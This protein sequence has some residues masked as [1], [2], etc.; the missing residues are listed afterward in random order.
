MCL[1]LALEP[2]PF[3]AL[4]DALFDGYQRLMPRN[5]ATAPAVIVA[6][7]ERALDAR[8]Q[9]PW[10][11]TL[12]AE[13]ISAIGAARPAAVGVDLLFVEPDRSS[14]GADAV[15]AQALQGQRVVMGIAGLTAGSLHPTALI[16]PLT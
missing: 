5:R 2:P 16:A 11:R 14:A 4:R 8:G 7:D 3:G 13:L 12:V 10:P 9:W 6:I 15:L 1:L